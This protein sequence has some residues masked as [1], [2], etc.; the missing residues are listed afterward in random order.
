MVEL[1]EARLA[2]NS[3]PVANINPTP[4]PVT[5]SAPVAA[6]PTATATNTSGSANAPPISASGTPAVLLFDP[7]QPAGLIP[8]DVTSGS[9][10]PLQQGAPPRFSYNLETNITGEGS[11]AANEPLTAPSHSGSTTPNGV[12]AAETIRGLP[13]DVNQEAATP[14]GIPRFS[15]GPQTAPRS[16]LQNRDLPG[17]RPG[18]AP[19][20]SNRTNPTQ[21]SESAPGTQPILPPVSQ[22]AL[23]SGTRAGVVVAQTANPSEAERTRIGPEEIA[24]G[25]PVDI[26]ACELAAV[27]PL[28]LP[29]PLAG[30]P[31]GTSIEPASTEQRPLNDDDLGESG[32]QTPSIEGALVSGALLTA[33]RRPRQES[34]PLDDVRRNFQWRSPERLSR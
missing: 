16:P 8:A 1:L 24:A 2:L 3:S 26:V 22:D 20:P 11:G 34:W 23:P 13:F 18:T 15:F 32:D 4:A 14:A 9:G 21:P 5:T 33:A 29:S 30:N 19:S 6:A 25:Q 28:N 31:L 27:M 7:H 17:M 12:P 10:P